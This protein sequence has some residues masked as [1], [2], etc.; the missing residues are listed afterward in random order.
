MPKGSLRRLARNAAGRS[1]ELCFSVVA[2]AGANTNIAISG[3]KAGRDQLVSVLEIPA[4]TTTLVD[5]TAATSITSDGNI[6]CTSSTSG[7]GVLVVY[8]KVV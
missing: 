6:Q 5:R 3:I 4:S 1:P 2:G 7:N 8:Y